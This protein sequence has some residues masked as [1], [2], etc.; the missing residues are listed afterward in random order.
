MDLKEF[1]LTQIRVA[2]LALSR[3]LGAQMGGDLTQIFLSGIGPVFARRRA[4][5]TPRPQR[6][7]GQMVADLAATFSKGE[8]ICNPVVR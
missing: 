6:R 7:G 4:R 1:H 5:L 2:E 8:Y 3:P